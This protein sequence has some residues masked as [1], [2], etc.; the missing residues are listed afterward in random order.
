MVSNLRPI[1]AIPRQI[2]ATGHWSPKHPSKSKADI[3]LSTPIKQQQR[4]NR[5][6]NN[7]YPRSCDSLITERMNG[8][9]TKKKLTYMCRLLTKF[10][11][12]T[13]KNPLIIGAVVSMGS[14]WWIPVIIF[15]I[16]SC[17]TIMYIFLC[18]LRYYC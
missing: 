15:I 4:Y 14:C 18:H 16:S 10:S 12:S 3:F 7:K 17:S 2:L 11:S 1:L 8:I 5:E 6:I 13:D 9:K